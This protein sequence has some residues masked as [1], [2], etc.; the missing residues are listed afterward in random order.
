MLMDLKS[1]PLEGAAGFKSFKAEFL[2]KIDEINKLESEPLKFAGFFSLVRAL[3]ADY[4]DKTLC[5]KRRAF[6]YFLFQF[7]DSSKSLS[8]VDPVTLFYEL[9]STLSGYL[10]LDMLNPEKIYGVD[11]MAA[12]GI[13][14]KVEEYFES[15]DL[16]NKTKDF[17]LKRHTYADLIY[18]KAQN[19]GLALLFGTDKA[20]D[21][22]AEPYYFAQRHIDESGKESVVWQLCIPAAFLEKVLWEALENYLEHCKANNI[23]PYA[24][25][26]REQKLALAWYEG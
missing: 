25:G 1:L 12:F 14:T 26:K 15:R 11:E 7:A 22:S 8:K 23:T 24:E 16:P 19:I 6:T 17:Y 13:V 9:Q 4:G 20:A 21:K 18:T 3:A 2:S 5:D 10:D